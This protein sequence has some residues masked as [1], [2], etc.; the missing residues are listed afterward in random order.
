MSKNS[1]KSLEYY[2]KNVDYTETTIIVTG[3]FFLWG[4]ITS[5]NGI[6]MPKLQQD[7]HLN[8]LQ[9]I[10]LQSA[11]FGA[12]FIISL[13][14]YLFSMIVKDP[15]ELLGFRR[16]II[17]GLV[18][19]G[20][21]C[22]MFYPATEFKKY[23]LFIG[24]LFVLASG[25]TLLQ[26]AANPYVALLGK[27]KNDASRLNM[28][29]AINSFGTFVA[30]L[31]SV[32]ITSVQ[33]PYLAL[34]ASI[35]FFAFLLS[36]TDFPVVLN[37]DRKRTALGIFKHKHVILG[38]LGIFMY[39]AGEV[40]VGNNLIN[41]ISLKEIGNIQKDEYDQYLML[42]W[43][44]AMV[45]RL[46]GAIMLSN[47]RQ[48]TKSLAI[49]IILAIA[50]L[51]GI[52]TWEHEPLTFAIII[53]SLIGLNLLISAITKFIPN[54][55]L[56][57]YAGVIIVMLLLGSFTTGRFAMWSIVGIGLFN[58]IMFPTIFTLALRG[59]KQY[60]SQGSALLVMGIVGGALIPPIQKYLAE[61]HLLGIQKSFLLP[62]LCYGYIMFYGLKGSSRK[63]RLE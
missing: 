48:A 11:F 5:M 17:L 13:I 35:F 53:L 15:I 55:T 37:Y 43:G 31:T 33:F 42:Y 54:K 59:L 3:L 56:G 12:Y 29:Q 10:L 24:A 7:F 6:L 47:L 45:G 50:F 2:K 62:V 61:D 51:G 36:T 46:I 32:L 25:I 34:A 18:I 58:S 8:D 44:G 27:E 20:V 23:E 19:T 1:L 60:I 26:L 40:S 38:A 49:Y 9:T 30:P 41:F 52:L 63:E 16:F 21:G 4:F 14:F 22:F 39:V 28:A 57:Y